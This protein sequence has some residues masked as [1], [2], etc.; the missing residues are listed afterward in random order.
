VA[1]PT[2]ATEAAI[3]AALQEATAAL[4][5]IRAD[6]QALSSGRS[7]SPSGWRGVLE[8]IERTNCLLDQVIA[9]LAD[10]DLDRG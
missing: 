10:H 2:G 6:L 4:E 8:Q 9:C 7:G 3:E 5:S 1:R